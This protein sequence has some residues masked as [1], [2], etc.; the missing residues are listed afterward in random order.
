MRRRNKDIWGTLAVAALACAP[1]A[2]HVPVA[3]T[4]VLGLALFASPGY[5]LEQVLPGPERGGLERLAVCA[6]LALCV[7]VIGGLVLYL[8]GL[9][10]DR[11]SWLGLLAGVTLLAGLLLFLRRR[12]DTGPV[13]PSARWL[14]RPAPCVAFGVAVLMAA[15]AVALARAGATVQ[16][17]PGFTQLWLAH[18][19]SDAATVNLGVSNDEG[20]TTR[21]QLVLLRH[22]HVADRWNLTLRNG[23]VWRR[24]PRYSENI[25]AH[26]Y[27]LPGPDRV[28]R[29]VGI[30][31]DRRVPR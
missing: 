3:V 5:L 27:R 11:A 20:A 29:E 13:P 7:P 12:R 8:A 9:R 1:A 26:L 30:G 22:G 24:S 18:P 15:G 4:A 23:Q 17:H 2:A 31:R 21:Y 16:Y 19:D 10:L 28:Y 14:P 6:G 25:A